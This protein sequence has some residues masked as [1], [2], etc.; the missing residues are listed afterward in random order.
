MELNAHAFTAPA[1]PP[2]HP[3]AACEARLQTFCRTLDA[4]ELER[5]RCTGTSCRLG[6]GQSLFH[7]GDPADII[8]N[9]MAGSLKMSHLLSDGRRQVIGFLFPGDFISAVPA[10]EFPFSVEA[11]EASQVCRF[12]RH[13]FET[14]VREHPRMEQALLNITA[15]DLAI[16]REQ[17]V[18]LGRKTAEEK[19]AS[20]LVGFHRP[21]RSGSDAETIRLPM[22][23]VDIAD[24]L[25]LTKETVSRLFTAFKTRGTIRLLPRGRIRI[26]DE[27][28]LIAMAA[29]TLAARG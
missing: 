10:D 11:L 18:L 3:C 1:L 26:L 25:G 21:S 16:A 19:F 6:S 8:C 17:L 24:Y 28:A 20:F 27:P 5:F 2:D 23:R 12:P 7:Q 14:F 22:S 29:G 13:R 4:A 9:V 15:R